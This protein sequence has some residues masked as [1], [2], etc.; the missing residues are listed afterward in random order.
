MCG[1]GYMCACVGVICVCARVCGHGCMCV[2]GGVVMCICARVGVVMWGGIMDVCVH[3][4]VNVREG[5]RDNTWAEN[6][7][8]KAEQTGHCG[9][10]S[11]HTESHKC[12]VL[13]LPPL[14]VVWHTFPIQRRIPWRRLEGREGARPL[15]VLIESLQAKDTFIE[16]RN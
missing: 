13:S 3:A 11:S 7:C 8:L 2:C 5:R 10:E 9:A 14:E 15:P 6:S 1:R 16:N 4:Y 12:A